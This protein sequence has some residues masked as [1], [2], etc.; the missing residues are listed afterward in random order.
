MNDFSHGPDTIRIGDLHVRRLG[1]G[2]MQ[3]PGPGVWGEPADPERARG[4]LRRAIELGIQFV[5]TSWYYGPLVSNRLIKEA[6]FPYPKDLIIATKLG[7]KRLQ[8]KSWAPFIKPS[9]LRQGCDEDLRT[10][11]LDHIDVAHLRWM[12]HGGASFHEALDGMMAL[13]SEGKIRN[14]GL[15]NV[16]LTQLREAC[17]KVPIV[18]VQ[19]LY[20]VA[21]SEKRL[22]GFPLGMVQG[23]EEMVDFCAGKG[24]A[25][26]PFFP[27]AVP[28]HK[29]V[30]SH[31]IARIAKEHQATTAQIAIAWL[32]ARSKTMLPIPGTGSLAH[33]EEN[34]AARKIALSQSEITEISRTRE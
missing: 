31:A 10:L 18:T 16:T 28:G 20:N 9:E 33:L 30:A 17:A 23:Q 32:L 14:I 24:I 21:A 5:D 22:S 2:A 19:N 6:L 4:V 26:L 7:G 29:Q 15:S 27:L 13:K 12:D 1:F 3:L 34:W 11:G 25:F 8:D